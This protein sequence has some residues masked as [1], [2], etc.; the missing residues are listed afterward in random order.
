MV[1]EGSGLTLS[2]PPPPTPGTLN[3]FPSN[4]SVAKL[5]ENRHEPK[6]CNQKHNSPNPKPKKSKK[7]REKSGYLRNEEVKCVWSP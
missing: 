6:P 5:L 7:G 1:H 2:E 3:P 4:K